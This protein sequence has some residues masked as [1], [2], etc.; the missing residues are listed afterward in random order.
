MEFLNH[1]D[2]IEN[3]FNNVA[4]TNMP[5]WAKYLLSEIQEL[6]SLIKNSNNSYYSSNGRDI[7]YNNFVQNIRKMLVANPSANYFPEIIYN[8]T[9]IGLDINNLLYYK[10]NSKNLTRNEAFEVYE[11]LYK[12]RDNLSNYLNI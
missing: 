11:F 7:N 8:N 3:S 4:S 9:K 1:L 12:H 6:K 5:V 10:H 2:N